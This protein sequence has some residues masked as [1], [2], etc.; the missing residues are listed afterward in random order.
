MRYGF[1]SG[2]T[3]LPPLPHLSLSLSL[4][5]TLTLPKLPPAVKGPILPQCNH[6]DSNE[7]TPSILTVEP[8]APPLSPPHSPTTTPTT[9][10]SAAK[11]D[12]RYN[13]LQLRN[14][15]WQ[16]PS[17]TPPSSPGFYAMG[18]AGAPMTPNPGDTVW[19]P[20][21]PAPYAHPGTP[22]SPSMPGMPGT[23]GAWH[24]PV[25]GT[26]NPFRFGGRKSPKKSPSGVP[27]YN[28]NAPASQELG[29][30]LGTPQ[31]LYP[32]V[33][34]SLHFLPNMPMS[35]QPSLSFENQQHLNVFGKEE[36]EEKGEGGAEGGA[37]G[38][39]GENR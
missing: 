11:F 25:Y 29:S 6:D 3:P 27:W 26:A 12:S 37:E 2:T 31:P 5:H 20:Q 13:D 8:F 14:R 35:P 34:G 23:P 24:Q 32:G 33:P 30:P 19:I 15:T 1:V 4:T 28:Y 17:L 18:M 16:V 39:G 9:P 7:P 10:T 38:G 21:S 36:F 22:Q